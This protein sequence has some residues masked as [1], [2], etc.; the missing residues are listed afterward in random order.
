M[1]GFGNRLVILVVVG[2]FCASTH[3]Q[4]VLVGS[5]LPADQGWSVTTNIAAPEVSTDGTVIS[6]NSI[7]T[8][9]GSGARLLF[10]KY[11]GVMPRHYWIEVKLKVDEIAAV[12]ASREAALALFGFFDPP[13]GNN[14]DA[15]L[16]V[17]Y[18][19]DEFGFG[20]L[21]DGAN[22]DTTDGFHTYRYEFIEAVEGYPFVR[23]YVD[24]V[25]RLIENTLHTPTGYIAFGDESTSSNRNS[26]Y[27][28]ESIVLFRDCNYDGVEDSPEDCDGDGNLDLCQIAGFDCNANNALDECDLADGSSLD[29]NGDNYPDECPIVNPPALEAEPGGVQKVKFI[30]FAP[31]DSTSGA[32]AIR[33]RLSSLHQ[34]NPPYGGSPTVPFTLFEGLS[35]WVGPPSTYVESAASNIPFRASFTQC[36]PHYRDWTSINLLHVTGSHIVPS[37]IYQLEQ[38][39][40]PCLDQEEGCTVISPPLEIRTARWGDV[41]EPFNPPSITVQP[42]LGD[43]SAIV[44]K[45]RGVPGAI[46]KARAL[47]SIN[48]QYGSITPST[49]LVDVGFTPIAS[50]VDAF[51]GARYPGQMGKCA[52]S[53]AAC[54][55]DATCGA[56]GPCALYCPD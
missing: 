33:I 52:S 25:L 29:L 22:F 9:T 14:D 10:Y 50:I 47:S 55:T 11:V 39:G 32:T 2:V 13:S 3:G 44:N 31:P 54:T 42:D 19:A 40:P 36:T 23:V 35:V 12:H 30:S 45:F 51:R 43:L 21:S 34:V 46:I 7:G 1:T 5:A 27:Q 18:D 41:E 28:I 56:N 6:V 17:Y 49:M 37:S 4:T 24:N 38:V 48:D 26:R 16:M 20:D 8:P 53:S 15:E